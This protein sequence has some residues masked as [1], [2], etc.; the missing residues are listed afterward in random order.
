MK[1]GF[2][3][4]LSMWLTDSDFHRACCVTKEFSC[5]RTQKLETSTGA[6]CTRTLTGRRETKIFQGAVIF[7]Y[8]SG[9]RN[10]AYDYA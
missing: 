7:I 4:F 5:Q 6:L 2:S 1:H 9:I 10:V 8:G 3:Y